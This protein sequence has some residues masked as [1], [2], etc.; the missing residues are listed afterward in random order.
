[1]NGN[2]RTARA[3][4]RDAALARFRKFL[5]GYGAD[6]RGATEITDLLAQ[7]TDQ[8]E[9]HAQGL[10]FYEA[11][12]GTVRK[13]SQDLRVVV[14]KFDSVNPHQLTVLALVDGCGCTYQETAEV[15]GCPKGTVRSRLHRARTSLKPSPSP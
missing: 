6:I 2:M 10:Y 11:F 13:H 15:I 14:A 4:S 8:T 12:C 3:Q 1:M 9:A 5:Q 7:N